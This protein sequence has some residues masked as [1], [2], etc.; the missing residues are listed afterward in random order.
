[1][2]SER[3]ARA[4]LPPVRLHVHLSPAVLRMLRRLA[5]NRGASRAARIRESMPRFL[6]AAKPVDDQAQRRRA[7][8]ALGCFASGAGELAAQQD[9]HLGA[10]DGP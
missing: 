9:R 7:L 5:W 10:A 4:K 6:Q 1:M 8:A 2:I 3:S